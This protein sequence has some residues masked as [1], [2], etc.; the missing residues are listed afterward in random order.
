[1]R[2]DAAI[3][4]AAN[5]L[6]QLPQNEA[7]RDARVLLGNLLQDNEILYR[8]PETEL[9]TAQ[10]EMYFNWI[11]RR[12][13]REPVSHII[14]CREFYSRSFKVT[15]DVLDP[16]ADSE[17]LIEAVFAEIEDKK[18][19]L[20]LLDLGTGSGCLAITL[21]AELKNAT[22]VAVDLSDKALEIASINAKALGVANRIE[23]RKG[24]WFANVTETFDVIVSNPPYIETATIDT[25]A[26][27][28]RLFEPMTALDGGDNGFV[29][30]D[31]ILQNIVPFLKADGY[32]IFEIGQGQDALLSQ[33][34]GDAGFGNIRFH[35]DLASIVRCVSGRLKS[36]IM[37]KRVGKSENGR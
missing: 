27:E 34:M 13:R 10:D 29:C 19:G 32:V 5:L 37:K 2:I 8:A 31:E 11:E 3:K 28:V 23:F 4:K 9:S 14:G 33:K 18:Q 20:K 16:R 15:A 21:I 1:M 6:S 12:G 7:R 30:Y 26:P 24:P 17:T 25:L 36:K 35:N 22:A